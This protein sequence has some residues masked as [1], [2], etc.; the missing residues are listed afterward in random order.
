MA[1]SSSFACKKP[2]DIYTEDDASARTSSVSFTS[3]F[4]SF[5]SILIQTHLPYSSI[6]DEQVPFLSRTTA[7]DA[8]DLEDGG[9]GWTR[10]NPSS[11]I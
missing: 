9:D 10:H 11:S 8:F 1:D 3:T 7:H 2:L 5:I 4:D 6:V